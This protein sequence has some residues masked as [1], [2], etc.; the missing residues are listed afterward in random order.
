MA[1][2]SV[3]FCGLLFKA[4]T[5]LASGILGETAGSLI[6]VM[7]AGAGAVVTKSIGLEPR[8]G[9]RNPTIVEIDGGYLNAIGLANP[10]KD[11]YTPELIRAV[12]H[13][14]ETGVHVI[15]SVYGAEPIEFSELAAWAEK[16]GASAVELNL[17]CP[18]A[19]GLG[20]VVGQ[21]PE[22]VEKVTRAAK[23]AV[24]IPVL[25]KLTPNITDITIPGVAAEKGGADAIVA[26]NTV[27]GMAVD[28]RAR[29]PIL[30]NKTGG[31]SGGAIKPVGLSCIWSL[32]KKLNTPLVG[33]GGVSSGESAIEYLM[34]GASLVQVGTAVREHGPEV[35]GKINEE[36]SELLDALGYG[37][38][39]EVVGVALE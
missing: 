36:I 2:L 21:D 26:I 23:D 16:S 3:E 18:H 17:S 11:D 20:S 19:K 29:K 33:V 34:V 25:V 4:P 30:S 27:R 31:I 10:G 22:K 5:V 9:Y 37:S 24:D 15:A 14:R 8:N 1:D 39:T 38:P 13:G 12:R 32:K 6:R 28:V 35:F 7:D